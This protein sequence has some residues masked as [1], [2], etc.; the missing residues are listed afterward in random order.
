LLPPCNLI[1]LPR[2]SRKRLIS[3]NEGLTWL[4]RLDLAI[5]GG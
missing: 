1:W 3:A 5:D 4:D 2:V